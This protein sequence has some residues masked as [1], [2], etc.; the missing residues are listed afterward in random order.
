M[1]YEALSGLFDGS[2]LE[3]VYVHAG[4][5]AIFLVFVLTGAASLFRLL[6]THRETML[7]GALL[8]SFLLPLLV[9][10]AVFA[11]YPLDV[12]AMFSVYS[13]AFRVFWAIVLLATMVPI[14][15]SMVKLFRRGP[16]VVTMESS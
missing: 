12:G 11:T 10:A 13:L 5:A 3:P 14:V 15:G 4:A 2:P 16:S 1:I 9:T 8:F 6:L 7:V